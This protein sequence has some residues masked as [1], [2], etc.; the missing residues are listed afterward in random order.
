MDEA[1]EARLRSVENR[2]TALESQ[3][4]A[5]ARQLVEIA[6]EFKNHLVMQ[7]TE[8]QRMDDERRRENERLRNHFDQ[9]FDGL[10]TQVS[11]VMTAVEVN[12][13]HV[14]HNNRIWKQYFPEL[15]KIGM[16]LGMI[17]AYL[18]YFSPG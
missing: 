5:H 16:T 9:K 2:A 18:K 1:Q 12:E 7:E 15:I 8:T 6:R 17:A 10:S 14:E 3:H 13:V 4:E 11:K